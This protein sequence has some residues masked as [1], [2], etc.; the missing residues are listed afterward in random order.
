VLSKELDEQVARFHLDA[1]GVEL[2]E[3]SKEQ[4]EYLQIPIDGPYKPDQYRY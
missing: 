3:L 2:T 1:L 4:S